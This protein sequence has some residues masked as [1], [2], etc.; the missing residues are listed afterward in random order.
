[1]SVISYLRLARPDHWVKNVFVLPGV[2]IA[3]SVSL[4]SFGWP[5]LWRLA[6]GL[7]ATCLIASSNYVINE[8]LDA[9]SD[10]HHPVKK[11]RPIPSGQIKLPLAYG[12]WFVLML[13]GMALSFFLSPGVAIG[14]AALWL[15]GLVY[16]VRPLR[17]KDIPYL[18]VIS[19]AVN[20]PIRMVIGWYIVG[21]HF[22]PPATVLMSYWMVG[23][24]FMAIK[25]FA[26]IRDLDNAHQAA[27]YRRSFAHYNEPRLLVSIIFYASAAMLFFGAFL[28]R[29]RLEWI[30]SFPLVAL[31]MAVYFRL[32]FARDGAAQAPEKLY[33]SRALMAAVVLCTVVMTALLFIDI[34]ALYQWFAP[35][36]PVR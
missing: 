2:V 29:Y 25:R 3:L 4:D 22:I 8:I 18:D 28:I 15:M 24:Y 26:E 36:V 27:L 9:P 17:T 1:M 6:I 23:C 33:R 10:R 34:P 21:V 30:L 7:A 14:L 13:A 35:T 11:N 31:V 20:N 19:E 32:A 12:L 16:N 5:L